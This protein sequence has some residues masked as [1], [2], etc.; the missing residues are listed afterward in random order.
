MCR[1]NK[2]TGDIFLGSLLVADRQLI[3]MN[4]KGRLRGLSVK[5]AKPF[6]ILLFH[7]FLNYFLHVF[8]ESF[9]FSIFCF[10]Y[11]IHLFLPHVS[12]AVFLF[13]LYINHSFSFPFY[14]YYFLLSLMKIFFSFLFV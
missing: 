13:S 2:K 4:E 7:S 14:K 9:T 6:F 5:K 10:N 12:M 3:K 8:F 11:F 1:A